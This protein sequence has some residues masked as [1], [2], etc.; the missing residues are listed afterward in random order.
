MRSTRQDRGEVVPVSSYTSNNPMTLA[1]IVGND[2]LPERQLSKISTR[3]IS[4]HTGLN[5]K[6]IVDII[7]MEHR[8]VRKLSNIILKMSN[9]YKKTLSPVVKPIQTKQKSVKDS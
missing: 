6:I 7:K 8:H 2:T 1:K 9:S 5:I 4:V 3:Y